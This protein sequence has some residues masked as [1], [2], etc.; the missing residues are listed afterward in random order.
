MCDFARGPTAELIQVNAGID[1]NSLR[2]DCGT[3]P[4]GE[5]CRIALRSRVPPIKL[6]REVIDPTFPYPFNR[7]G[8]K[9]A[10]LIE[11]YANRG[12]FSSGIDP[13]RADSEQSMWPDCFHGFMQLADEEI[14]IMPAPIVQTERAAFRPKPGVSVGIWRIPAR[15]CSGRIRVKIIIQDDPRD[16][17][18]IE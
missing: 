9:I 12:R 17:V 8:I 15:I 2:I 3:A 10:I 16:G 18:P 14:D 4:P 5:Q 7:I 13:K 1:R 6:R 11:L